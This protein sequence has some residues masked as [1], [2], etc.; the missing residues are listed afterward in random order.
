MSRKDQSSPAYD[1]LHL[2]KIRLAAENQNMKATIKKQVIYILI[3][4]LAAISITC[5]QKKV[6]YIYLYQDQ[7]L[8]FSKYSYEAFTRYGNIRAEMS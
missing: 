3:H 4:I 8:K 7:I 1:K 2:E 5:K 6:N